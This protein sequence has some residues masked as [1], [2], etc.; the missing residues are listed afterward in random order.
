MNLRKTPLFWLVLLIVLMG[1][2]YG[3][4]ALTLPGGESLVGAVLLMFVF[5]SVTVLALEQVLVSLFEPKIWG[6][7]T[8]DVL[9][10]GAAFGVVSPFLG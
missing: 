9:M 7:L 1:T 5:A 2:P 6:V 4:Y 3:F 10:A 8:I